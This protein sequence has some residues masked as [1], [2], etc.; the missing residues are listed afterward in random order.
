MYY[1]GEGVRQNYSQAK[2]WFELAAKQGFARAQFLLGAM[3]KQGHGVRQ[4]LSQAKEWFGKA[5]DNGIQDGCDFYRELS[6]VVQ[7]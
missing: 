1:L 6:V 5:C 4:N 7:I 3:N 2:H